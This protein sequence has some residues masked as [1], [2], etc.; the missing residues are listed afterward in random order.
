MAIFFEALNTC[1]AMFRRQPGRV[2]AGSGLVGDTPGVFWREPAAQ[3]MV[4][5]KRR[6]STEHFLCQISACVNLYTYIYPSTYLSIYQSIYLSIYFI[7][8][9]YLIYLLCVIRRCVRTFD[10]YVRWSHVCRTHVRIA[11]SAFGLLRDLQAPKPG[12]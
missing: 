7:Y 9:V 8:L 11:R 2:P 3:E 5:I 1:P 12:M 10:R 6:N 4:V